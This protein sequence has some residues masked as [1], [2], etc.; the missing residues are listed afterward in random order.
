MAGKQ[1]RACLL[2]VN[3][4]AAAEGDCTLLGLLFLDFHSDNTQR[5][6]TVSVSVT[7]AIE[8]EKDSAEETMAPTE[9]ISNKIPPIE[10]TQPTSR[11]NPCSMALIQRCLGWKSC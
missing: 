9:P 10:S 3:L 2:T 7:D 5:S 11:L 8:R 6:P 4:S 1:I